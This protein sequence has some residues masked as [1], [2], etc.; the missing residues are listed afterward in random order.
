VVSFK[1]NIIVGKEKKKG[2]N[3]IVEKVVR[4]LVENNLHIK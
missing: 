2:Y 3:K 4:K 1:D